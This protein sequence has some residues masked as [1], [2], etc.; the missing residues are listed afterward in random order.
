LIASMSALG[1]EE[2][3]PPHMVLAAGF[4]AS[5]DTVFHPASG[6]GAFAIGNPE[7][8]APSVLHA[9]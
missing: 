3:R 8:Q 6:P 1:D 4:L 9:V 7:G 5:S 2:K